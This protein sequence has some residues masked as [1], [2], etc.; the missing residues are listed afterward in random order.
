MI[1]IENTLI[2]I[3]PDAL[4]RNLVGSILKIYEENNLSIK[5]IKI[6]LAT[7]EQAINH[8]IEHKEKTFFSDLIDYITSG[9]L[10]A[11]I[12]EGENAI[13]KARSI[14]NNIREIYGIDSTKNSVHGSDSPE[15]VLRETKIW[16]K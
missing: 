5:N 3:K 14:N 10:V 8:Y 4:K 11:V 13:K 6:L 9:E 16:F 7:K 1:I 2:L 15:S 12:L